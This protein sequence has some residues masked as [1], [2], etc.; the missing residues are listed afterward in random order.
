MSA[1]HSP[2]PASADA[3]PARTYWVTGASSG[4]GRAVAA[5]LLAAGHR[6]IG[7]ARDFAKD[8]LADARFEAASIDLSR[9]GELPARLAE[10]LARHGDP[11]GAIL[12]AG[13]GLFKFLEQCSFEEIRAHLDLN[14]AS[15]MLLARAVLPALKRRGGDLAIIGSEAALRGRKRGAVYCAARFGLRGF[16]QALREE[17]ASSEVRIILV[18]PGAVRSRFF[19]ALDFAPGEAPE[20]A[21]LPETVADAVYSALS[22]ARGAVFEEITLTPLKRVWRTRSGRSAGA[23]LEPEG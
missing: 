22:A 21:I 18:H 14:L 23:D 7:L 8:P 16:A 6:V 4:I 17:C 19:D 12:C 10:L 15:P 1:G 9:L 13:V 11:D 5:R 3:A 2:R 20:N